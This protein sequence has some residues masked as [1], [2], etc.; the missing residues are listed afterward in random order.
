MSAS[1]GRT[2]TGIGSEIGSEI[3]SEP[4]ECS[5]LGA[6]LAEAL[7]R[8]CGD[9]AATDPLLLDLI[10]ALCAA[11]E[12]G[13]LELPLEGPAP[14]ELQPRLW[15]GAYLAA[16]EGSPLVVR[17]SQLAEK[18]EA[19]LV[20]AGQRLRWRRWH[21]QLN[22]VIAALIERAQEPL[23]PVASATPL[24][25]AAPLASAN[26]VEAARRLAAAG[27]DTAQQRAVASLLT[28]RLVLVCG[29][30]GTGK[31][32]TVVAM[33]A[34]HLA[35]QPAAKLHLAAPTGKAATRL[36][37]AIESGCERLASAAATEVLLAAPCSTLHRLLESNGHR[38]GRNH[39]QPLELDLLVVDELSMVDLPL[40]AALLD[41]LPASCRLVLVGDPAQLPPVG[42]GAVLLELMEP[43]RLSALG[44][45]VV[46]LVTSYRNSGAIAS[47]AAALRPGKGPGEQQ[48]LDPERWPTQANKSQPAEY[49]L[50]ASQ[51]AESQFT[52]SQ[53]AKSQSAK[54]Q[55]TES[56]SEPFQP[57]L[58]QLDAFQ[59][60]EFHSIKSNPDALESSKSQLKASQANKPQPSKFRLAESQPAESAAADPK[61]ELPDIADPYWD[62][63]GLSGLRQR[64]AQLRPG[65]NLQWSQAAA[66]AP[67]PA[68]IQRLRQHQER[69][70]ALANAFSEQW[71]TA[72][73]QLITASEL[74]IT[75][76]EEWIAVS[77]QG[78][79]AGPS[80]LAEGETA[81]G[82]RA[83]ATAL[84]AELE[85]CILLTPLRLGSWGV[86]A[87]HRQLLGEQLERAP[88]DWPL[89]T[90]VLNRRNLPEQGLANGD[91]GVVVAQAGERRL[92]FPGPRL[93]H[94]AR[95]GAAEPALALT[96]HKAQGSQY[97]EVWLLLPPGRSWDAR[98]LY[99]G[100]TRA[101]HRAWL[102]TP[103]GTRNPSKPSLG[104]V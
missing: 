93:L 20:L 25:S 79:T 46:E 85:R 4:A 84:L 72:G 78:I 21:L 76:S 65:D 89:G 45:A 66:N 23:A 102:I 75:A 87:I 100:L 88:A 7:P 68:A 94:P 47:V 61:L 29:G 16:L 42:P 53:P 33:L 71:I 13:Q 49:Q 27:L 90:P 54:P 26:Q 70:A 74:G 10:A 40:M 44:T 86:A 92:L 3:V 77:E 34:A 101:Q 24:A 8:L 37:Y 6:A 63:P 91:I 95:I 14:P 2:S 80:P 41:A 50:N 62:K 9:G 43:E 51:P 103:H 67:P 28:Q 18:P 81:A 99:T 48:S 39:R 30:P 22:Q 32:S 5:F 56:P 97:G 11:L 1:S 36:R 98:L 59:P 96:V 69:L 55:P 57:D 31:T 19:P 35:L 83:A 52:A 17:A 38:Y 82:A 58:L 12:R 60:N 15:P 64:L 73:D 104:L